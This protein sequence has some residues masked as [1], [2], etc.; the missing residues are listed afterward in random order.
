MER[1]CCVERLRGPISSLNVCYWEV[2]VALGKRFR[3]LCLRGAACEFFFLFC[4]RTCFADLFTGNDTWTACC[5]IRPRGTFSFVE[6]P[7]NNISVAE[8]AWKRSWT[9]FFEQHLVYHGGG[10]LPS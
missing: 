8:K 1:L 10:V 4:T 3:A 5:V 9:T 2:F 6:R 7:W